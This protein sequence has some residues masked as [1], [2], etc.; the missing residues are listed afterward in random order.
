[1]SRKQFFRDFLTAIFRFF[2]AFLFCSIPAALITSRSSDTV[3]TQHYCS[4]VCFFLASFWSAAAWKG[5][6]HSLLWALL[7]VLGAEAL[8]LTIGAVSKN[9]SLYGAFNLIAFSL[10]GIL[11]A[12]LILPRSA[13]KGHNPA[14]R[15]RKLH[16]RIF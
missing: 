5:R 15:M 16:I 7:T 3:V 11:T 14:P 6:E 13:M 1:M 4:S 12:H 9:T 10:C 8:L 2:C